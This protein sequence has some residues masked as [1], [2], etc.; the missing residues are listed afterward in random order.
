VRDK[1]PELVDWI[2]EGDVQTFPLEHFVRDYHVL[3]ETSPSRC[4]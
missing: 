2:E 3:R 4:E 1:L